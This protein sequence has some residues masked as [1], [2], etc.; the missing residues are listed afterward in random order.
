MKTFVMDIQRFAEDEGLTVD[1]ALDALNGKESEAKPE[2][3]KTKETPA[4]VEE[5]P[6]EEPEAEEETKPEAPAVDFTA[7][8]KFRANG[9]EQEQSLQDLINAAQ[10][11]SN[12]NQKMQEL[13]TQ[14]KAFELAQP[15]EVDPAKD[16]EDLDRM[17]TERAMKRLHITD[18][19]EFSPD[20]SINRIH[21]AAYQ[22]AL[23][24]INQEKQQ[25]DYVER[26]AQQVENTF[27][28]KVNTLAAEADFKEVNQFAEKELY[29]LPAK[30]PD[31]IKE[32]NQLYPVMQ[33]LKLRDAMFNAG[34]DYRVVRLT[35]AEV[36]AITGFY[37]TQKTA[38]VSQKNKPAPVVV[39]KG[40]VIKPTVR[41][42]SGTNEGPAPVKKI[43]FKK[44][45][46][47]DLEEVAKLLNG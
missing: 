26:E 41:V 47:M 34:Q 16:F 28:S 25:S 46:E 17:I 29:N 13:A 14:R 12:Y 11:G 39:P 44:V 31:G 24:E 7:K 5:K 6:E 9:V 21:F 23:N 19:D 33:K 36:N 43:D 20:A 32:F 4:V 3:A 27:V 38:Y 40:A 37:E 30:G 42:E 45:R 22:Q 35:T 10:L 1:Q 15:K 8:I 2:A 18:P